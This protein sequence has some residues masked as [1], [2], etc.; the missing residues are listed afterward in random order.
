MREVE[1]RPTRYGLEVGETEGSSPWF[2][3]G[4]VSKSYRNGVP[5][6]GNENINALFEQMVNVNHRRG[7][8]LNSWK[9]VRDTNVVEGDI[10][11]NETIVAVFT[12]QSPGAW[13]LQSIVANLADWHANAIDEKNA[14]KSTAELA[15]IVR[16]AC[17][18]M[19]KPYHEEE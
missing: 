13:D 12:R 11:C 8:A 2:I 19:R 15:A 18:V 10:W 4:E 5:I 9:M 14:K 6:A 17:R 16:E 7:Y 1:I 3:V